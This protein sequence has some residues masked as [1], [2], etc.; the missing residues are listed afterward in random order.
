LVQ[1]GEVTFGVPVCHHLSP[2]LLGVLGPAGGCR[3]SVDGPDSLHRLLAAVLAELPER[4]PQVV[5]DGVRGEEEL[6]TP[7]EPEPDEASPTGDL[8][9]VQ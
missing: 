1:E 8:S 3:E 4:V 5:L 9:E 6:R 7:L 2:Y